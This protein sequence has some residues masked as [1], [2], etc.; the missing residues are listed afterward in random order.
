MESYPR[1]NYLQA[2]P[3]YRLFLIFDNG[4]IKIYSLSERLESPAFAPLK[5]EALF[6][7]V[8]VANGGYGVIWNDEL[9]LSE[10]ELWMKGVEVSKISELVAKVA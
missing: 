8:R 3:N 2:L 6:N 10:Y 1:I 7:T 4:E 5:D 9:D